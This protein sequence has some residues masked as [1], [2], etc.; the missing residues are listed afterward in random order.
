MQ[1]PQTLD[2][3][4]MG[5]EATETDKRS[6]I[7]RRVMTMM[8]TRARSLLVKLTRRSRVMRLILSCLVIMGKP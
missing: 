5:G 1:E 7:I 8:M 3:C 2:E 4:P 6:M